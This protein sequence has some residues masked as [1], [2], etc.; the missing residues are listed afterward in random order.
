[1]TP[2]RVGSDRIPHRQGVLDVVARPTAH[3]AAHAIGMQGGDDAARSASPIVAGERRALD[4]QSVQQR[5]QVGAQGGLLS[6][7]RRVRPEEAGGSVTAQP[8]NDDAPPRGRE[9]ASDVVEAVHVVGEAVQQ[10]D[11]GPVL[12][13]LLEVADVQHPRLHMLHRRTSP[14]PCSGGARPARDRCGAHTRASTWWTCASS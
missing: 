1:M 5:E 7:A 11:R 13:T 8:R 4:P 12:R 9:A 2:L 14:L 3:Q 6:D 10:D